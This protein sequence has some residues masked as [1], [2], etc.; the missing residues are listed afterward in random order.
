MNVWRMWL[1]HNLK[2]EWIDLCLYSSKWHMSDKTIIITDENLSEY[3]P[4]LRPEVWEITHIVAASEYIRFTLIAKYGGVWLDAD[5]IVMHNLSYLL[6]KLN[7][8]DMILLREQL[9]SEEFY[10]PG[11][12]GAVRDS[13][14]IRLALQKYDALLDTGQREFPWT[15]GGELLNEAI[16]ECNP[17]KFVIHSSLTHPFTCMEQ[18]ELV[19]D[20]ISINQRVDRTAPVIVCAA[21]MFRRNNYGNLQSWTKHEIWSSPSVI[22]QLFRRSFNTSLGR[23]DA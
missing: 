4:E 22:G 13:K 9:R 20:S 5:A 1:T 11:F 15:V 8:H 18:N 21:E 6:S 23:W 10:D 12:F 16:R 3:L 2:P 19:D 14:V 17:T 7:S